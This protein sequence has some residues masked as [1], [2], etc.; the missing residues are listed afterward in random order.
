MINNATIEAAIRE[1]VFTMT[2][3]MSD[4]LR[5]SIA[6]GTISEALV[7]KELDT[8]ALRS[9]FL[10]VT[11]SASHMAFSSFIKELKKEDNI[12]KLTEQSE[13]YKQSSANAASLAAMF[14]NPKK[15]VLNE[16]EIKSTVI[17]P[18]IK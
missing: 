16:K 4:L 1:S 11:T 7:S 8:N 2:T 18:D 9:A 17:T 13:S 5:E 10:S 15:A 12:H 6:N 3:K 14:A